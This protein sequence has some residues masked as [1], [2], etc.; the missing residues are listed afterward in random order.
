MNDQLNTFEKEKAPAF[1]RI[2]NKQYRKF[3]DTGNIDTISESQIT[4]IIEN[5]DGINGKYIKEARA[6]VIIMYYTGAR[7]IEVLNIVAGDIQ[8]DGDY[9][10]IQLKGF[11]RGLPRKVY[12]DFKKPLVKEVFN[13]SKSVFS[14]AFLFYHYKANYTRTIKTKTGLVTRKYETPKLHGYFKR[15]FSCVYK[16]GLPPY[17]L[18]HNRFSKLSEAGASLEEIRLIKGAKSFNSVYPYI[19]LSTATAKKISSKID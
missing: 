3:L 19:H 14:E 1:Q 5:I 18:R 13:Y 12:L 11:K 2:T 8:K 6:L 10:T 16:N 7:P 9:I 4:K 17:F 15:W